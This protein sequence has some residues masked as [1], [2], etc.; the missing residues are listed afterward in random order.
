MLLVTQTNPGTRKEATTQGWER[1]ARI[2]GD[3]LEGLTS[4]ETWGVEIS[5]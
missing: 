3:H 2:T 4:T 5:L 1:E